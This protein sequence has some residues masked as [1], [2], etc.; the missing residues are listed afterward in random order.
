MTASS[1]RATSPAPSWR[2]RRARLCF[3]IGPER[4]LPIFDGLDAP[5]ARWSRPTTSSAPACSTTRSRRRRTTATDAGAVARAQAVHGLR[6]SGPRGRAR[7][8]ARSIARARS[9]TLYGDARRRGALRRQAASADLR[10]GARRSREGAARRCR[11]RARPR[12]GDRRIR[13]A[14]ISRARTISASTA[15]SSPPASTPRSSATAT[16]PDLAALG[17]NVRRRRHRAEGGDAQAGVV[18]LIDAVPSRRDVPTAARR[19][20]LRS[21]S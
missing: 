18:T 5:F 19:T 3:I 14:P 12:A 11:H 2:A 9:P 13:C 20:P 4:D 7:R 16:I 21:W 6:Q 17:T 8:Q 1:A 10:S 15:C